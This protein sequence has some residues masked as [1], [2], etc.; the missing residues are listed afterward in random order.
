[1]SCHDQGVH[2]GQLPRI[3]AGNAFTAGKHRG[4]CQ[5][6]QLTAVDKGFQDVLLNGEIIVAEVLVQILLSVCFCRVNDSRVQA[7]KTLAH[8]SGAVVAFPV[9]GLRLN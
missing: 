4:L 5:L 7:A 8:I 1:V 3:Q 6:T 2:Q 9:S